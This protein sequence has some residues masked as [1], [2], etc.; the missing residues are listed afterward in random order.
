MKEFGS[1]PGMLNS[2]AGRDHYKDIMSAVM[3]GGGVQGGRAIGVT[4]ALGASVVDPGWSAGRVMQVEDLACTIYS[5]LGIDYTK[6]IA[7][8]PSGRK[9]Y[10]V[11]GASTGLYQPV[12][13]VFG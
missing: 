12:M 8:T 9:F 4:D 5:A 3:I 2:R 11:E 13:E 6:S 7:D 10:Y 1:K